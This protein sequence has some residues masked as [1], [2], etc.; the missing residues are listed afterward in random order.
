MILRLLESRRARHFAGGALAASVAIHLGLGSAAVRTPDPRAGERPEAL[1]IR[2]LLP[3]D[4]PHAVAVEHIDWASIGPGTNGWQTGADAAN[5]AVPTRG[6]DDVAEASRAT[7]VPVL[8][9]EPF[10]QALTYQEFEVDSAATRDPASGGPAYPDELRAKG[11]QGEVL[12]EFAVDTTGHADSTTFVVVTAS[13][14]EFA[15]A[16]RDALP[17]ML[18][19]PAVANG[20]RV[21][22]LVRLPMKFKLL[23]ETAASGTA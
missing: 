5:A 14:P 11:V 23:T 20:R 13:H 17:Q 4:Q 1:S 16:V 15:Q 18:F 6:G 9:E 21:R 7:E 12:V 19:T 3:P 8:E 10:Q 2:Y 22:Q